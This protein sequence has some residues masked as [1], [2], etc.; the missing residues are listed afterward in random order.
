ML[1]A[2]TTITEG[3]R[4]VIPSHIRKALNIHIGEEVLLKIESGELHIVTLRN[5]VK[6]AQALISKYNK[7]NISLKDTLFSM[8][9]EEDNDAK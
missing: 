2:R 4:M 1:E 7:K 3:G 9:K 5:S 6:N 8:R